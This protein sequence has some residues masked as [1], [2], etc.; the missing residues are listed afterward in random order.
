MSKVI[1]EMER[2]CLQECDELRTELQ[3]STAEITAL[4][5]AH[6]ALLR[7]TQSLETALDQEREKVREL[8]ESPPMA[9]ISLCCR[10]VRWGYYAEG[11]MH[12]GGCRDRHGG[13]LG[14]TYYLHDVS[15]LLSGRGAKESPH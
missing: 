10:M 3:E 5:A 9:S 8:A 14:K 15:A 6:E 13:Q 11:S 1:V 7:R 4:R 12:D 2:A